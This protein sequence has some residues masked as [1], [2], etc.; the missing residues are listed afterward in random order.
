[1][2]GR[3]ENWSSVSGRADI[4]R[5]LFIYS[6]NLFI[7]FIN[8]L[9]LLFFFSFTKFLFCMIMDCGGGGG[10]GSVSVCVCV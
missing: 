6:S 1:M 7:G 2:E 4:P 10:G 5:N 8:M 3:R 9:L